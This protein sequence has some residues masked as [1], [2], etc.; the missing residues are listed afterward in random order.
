[1]IN[2][3][4][5]PME[6]GGFEVSPTVEF[7]AIAYNQ[8]GSEDN[9]EYSLTMPSDNKLSVE[10]GLGVYANK[11]IGNMKFNA[12]L[13][14]YREFADPYNVKMGMNGMEGT[15]NLYDDRQEYRG[16]AS[17]GFGYDLNDW[18]VYGKVQHFMENDNHTNM[19]AGIK[20][21]F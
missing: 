17:F 20:Y 3:A 14:M 1:L 7:N 13:M 8:K 2:E 18:N 15:F 4:R 9:K 12:G 5:Y 10:A 6:M 16:V 21:T 19:K 11:A